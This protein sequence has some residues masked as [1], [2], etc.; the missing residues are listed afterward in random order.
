MTIISGE[1]PYVCSVPGCGKAYSNS[2]DRFKHS[3][4]HQVDKPYECRHPGCGKRYTDPSS[5]RK[6]VKIYSHS[7]KK[8]DESSLSNIPPPSISPSS[9]GSSSLGTSPIPM[10][11]TPPSLLPASFFSPSHSSMSGCGGAGSYSSPSSAAAVWTM[12][13]QQYQI[14]DSFR[15]YQTELLLR[16]R[17]A[18]SP[19]DLNFASSGFMPYSPM[20]NGIGEEH[21]EDSRD[22]GLL[23]ME[24]PDRTMDGIPELSESPGGMDP[25]PTA[26]DLSTSPLD[27]SMPSAR[28]RYQ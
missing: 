10:A 17:A 7:S 12:A 19:V 5:L 28:R 15:Q 20:S 3:R 9:S 2:S 8:L 11:P 26:L 24:S 16:G 4:T 23:T 6:H 21:E 1:K 13:L 27:L 18:V 22:R 14:N 25:D